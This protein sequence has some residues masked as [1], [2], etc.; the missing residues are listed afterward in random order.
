MNFIEN[1]IHKIFQ[2]YKISLLIPLMVVFS[3]LIVNL[4]LIFFDF[5]FSLSF[6]NNNLIIEDAKLMQNTIQ[7]QIEYFYETGDI[8]QIKKIIKNF[9]IHQSIDTIDLVNFFGL[10][11]ASNREKN[12]DTYVDI[13]KV[14]LGCQNSKDKIICI[15]PIFVKEEPYGYLIMSIKREVFE[16]QIIKFLSLRYTIHLAIILIASFILMFLLNMSVT[17]NLKIISEQVDSIVRGHYVNPKKIEGNNEFAKISEKLNKTSKRLWELI[18]Y[19]YLTRIPNRYYIVKAF[20][21]LKA[22]NKERLFIGIIDIDNFKEINDFFG[23]NMGDYLLMEFAER[24]MKISEENKIFVGRTGGD[25]FMIFGEYDEYRKLQ[26]LL[27]Y[28]KEKIEGIYSLIHSN[29]RVT[30]SIGVHLVSKFDNFY[31]AMKK[32]DLALYRSKSMGKGKITIYTKEMHKYEERQKEILNLISMA[33]DNN[34]FYIVFQPIFNIENN[35]IH[36]YEALLRWNNPKLGEVSPAEFIPMIEK[37]GMI[38]EVGK[39]VIKEAI[40]AQRVL[41]KPIHINIS[42]VQLFDS[43]IVDFIR[44]ECKEK[45]VSSENIAIELIETQEIFKLKEIRDNINRLK[46]HG[47]YISLDD[48]GTGFSNIELLEEI[49]PDSIKIDMSLTKEIVSDI[50]HRHI[51]LSI[52]KMAEVLGIKVIAEGVDSEEKLE[53]LR[54]LGV[55]YMQGFY[56]GNPKKI[57]YY[58]KNEDKN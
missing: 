28:I 48:F 38:I 44:K 14:N 23:H 8:E 4:I 47:Y 25:E 32:S 55:K 15:N 52:V 20:S 24:L 45:G 19:D 57:D 50:T 42:L 13:K 54:E 39:Y 58:I 9:S 31:D 3:A 11:V 49:D 29:V 7:Q 26:E 56:L 21:E 53:V 12:I 46:Y 34:E 27:S 36:S 30:V 10:V 18:H 5:R 37:T 33:I 17:K 40:K 51:V 1:K 6:I 43:Q 41:N 16:S 22:Q 2:K 35:E